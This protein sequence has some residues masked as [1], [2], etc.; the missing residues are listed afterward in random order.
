MRMIGGKRYFGDDGR[1]GVVEETNK[2]RQMMDETI[3]VGGG[4]NALDVFPVLKWVGF[5]WIEKK[6]MVVQEK[7]DRFMQD[8]VEEHKRKMEI[9]HK[10][11][12]KYSVGK[13][14]RKKTIIEVMLSLQ[15]SD[16]EFYKDETIKSLIL[17]RPTHHP[18]I[19]ID[20]ICK[21]TAE[22]PDHVQVRLITF[23]LSLNRFC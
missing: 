10:R 9:D 23:N 1:A 14:E 11:E 19:F 17:V 20:V 3:R 5:G 6:F 22:N 8:L 16:T 13:T 7:R 4:I 21:G 12:F 18:S 15:G 2:F